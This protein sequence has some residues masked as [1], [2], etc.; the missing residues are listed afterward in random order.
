LSNSRQV[1]LSEFGH[2]S[3]VYSLQPEATRHLLNIFF[4][5]GKADDSLFVHHTVNFKARMSFPA[6][7]KLIVV[8]IVL[9]IVI[10]IAGVWFI[11]RR[12]RQRRA[13]QVSS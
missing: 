8:A 3:D 7:A 10:V 11:I 4:A 13:A 9:V 12:V 6:M 2:T 5:T 1:I